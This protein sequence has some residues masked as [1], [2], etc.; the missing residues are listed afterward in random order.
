MSRIEILDDDG[1]VIDIIIAYPE[2]AEEHY[3]GRWRY[4]YI[5]PEE[6]IETRHPIITVFAFR[7]RFTTQERVA[8][9]RAALYNPA[10]DEQT[11]QERAEL[12]TLLN[13]LAS[14]RHIYLLHTELAAG[15]QFLVDR[16][17]LAQ[18]RVSEILSVTID[19]EERP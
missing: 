9:E 14:A 18:T 8:I 2:Y 7:K 10:D 13:D 17:L 15:M 19:E 6:P 3:P 11:Q 12:R 16:G 5:P 4:Q 1:N